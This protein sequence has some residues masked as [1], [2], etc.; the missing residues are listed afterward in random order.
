M[1]S[2]LLRQF[3]NALTSRLSHGMIIRIAHF[4]V[5]ATKGGGIPGHG[6]HPSSSHCCRR[7]HHVFLSFGRW[8]PLPEHGLPRLLTVELDT[9][10]Y[11]KSIEAHSGQQHGDQIPHR[12]FKLRDS[13]F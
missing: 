6:A 9:L 7:R 3:R 12:R 5:V 4:R 13:F 8:V 1:L 10:G 2:Q 11:V